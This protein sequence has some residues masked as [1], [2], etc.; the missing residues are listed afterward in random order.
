MAYETTDQ[1]IAEVADHWNKKKD[2]VFYQL[3]DSYNS[4]LE[5]ISDENEKIA[6]WRSI[7]KAKGT[8]LD[9]IGQDYKAYRISDDDETFR[10]II[11]LHILISRAQGTIP[12]MVKILGTALNAKPEQFKVYKTGL[13]HVGIEIPWDNVQTLQMQKFIIKNIQNLL[14][15]GYWIDEIVFVTTTKLPLYVGMGTQI[16]HRKI[17]RS[18][19]KWWTGWKARTSDK[20]YIGIATQFKHH[21]TL[22]SNTKWWTGWKAEST[23]SQFIGVVGQLA[24]SSVWATKAV[25]SKP[26]TAEIHA[27]LTIGNKTLTTTT[28]SIATE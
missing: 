21:N 8:T 13:R 10:F 17:E 2:T 3:L 9:L 4:L 28:Q 6:E 24:K 27:G 18:P 25:W 20:Q 11:F 14:A 16:K 12:S 7:D 26:Q 5:K 1:L 23:R 22:S 15:M 19:V